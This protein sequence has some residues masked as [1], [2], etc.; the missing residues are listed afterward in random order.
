VT[1][2]DLVWLFR[3]KF[4]FAPV[5]LADTVQIW[6]IIIAWKLIQIDTYLKNLRQGL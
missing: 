3:V 4:C 2:N 5:W 6:N 1:L